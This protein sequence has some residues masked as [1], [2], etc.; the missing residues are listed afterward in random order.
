VV[1][2]C[3]GTHTEWGR[4]TQMPVSLLAFGDLKRAAVQP[5]RGIKLVPKGIADLP[6]AAVPGALLHRHART[7]ERIGWHHLLDC[8]HLICPLLSGS[9]IVYS[10]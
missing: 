1:L 8:C 10:R 3:K 4:A 9:G 2:R 5:C 6:F 7:P